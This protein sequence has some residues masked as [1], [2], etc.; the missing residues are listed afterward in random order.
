MVKSRVYYLLF[1]V[2]TI[3]CFV[4]GCQRLPDKI[5]NL[6]NGRIYSIGHGG[7]GVQPFFNYQPHNTLLSYHKALTNT[8]LDGVEM[9]VQMTGDNQLVLFHDEK[10]Q[11][12]TFCTGKVHE[13]TLEDLRKCNYS[14]EW[15]NFSTSNSSII[16]L[17]EALFDLKRIHPRGIFVLDLKLYPT[18]DMEVYQWIFAKELVKVLVETECRDNV[19]IESPQLEML[20]KIKSIDSTLHLFLYVTNFMDGIERA[21]Q[22][23]LYGLTIKHSLVN[24]IQVQQAHEQGLRVSVWGPRSSSANSNAISLHPDYIQT[25][26]L[27]DLT[28]KLQKYQSL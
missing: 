8:K 12:K 10:L 5:N 21:S 3:G 25:D 28:N 4:V 24:K 15:I 6:N 22:S 19:C 17:K 18:E 23:G 14:K 2:S 13:M 27:S 16:T 7:A 1:Y 11:S 9:D 20:E 26:K